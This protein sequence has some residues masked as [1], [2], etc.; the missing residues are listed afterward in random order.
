MSAQKGDWATSGG[1]LSRR[2]AGQLSGLVL[3]LLRR[4]GRAQTPAEV[5]QQLTEAGSGPLAYTTVVTTLTRLHEQGVLD[6]YRTGRAYAY[7]AIG[8]PAKV[9][10]RRMRRMLEAENDRDAVLASFVSELSP[11]DERALRDVLGADF[12]EPEGGVGGR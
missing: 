8:D 7:L 6:R 3:E 12:G 5:L 4:D 10:G 9:T 2:G 1:R 11:D